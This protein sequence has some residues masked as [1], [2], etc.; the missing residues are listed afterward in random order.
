[1]DRR[2]VLRDIGVGA[3]AAVAWSAPSIQSVAYAA[4]LT[5]GPCPFTLTFE[6][7]G[8]AP[9]RFV[10]IIRHGEFDCDPGS[11]ATTRLEFV[12]GA[13][14]AEGILRVPEDDET[15]AIYPVTVEA[16]CSTDE[17]TLGCPARTF[18]SFEEL[19]QAG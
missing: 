5:S 13:I 3:G 16:M 6:S 18:Q 15:F 14:F 17:P 7:G 2:Q 19:F 11:V 8:T 9:H 4:V 10:L 12:G 1:M